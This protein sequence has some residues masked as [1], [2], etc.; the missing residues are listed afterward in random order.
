MTFKPLRLTVCS[1]PV[2]GLNFFPPECKTNPKKLASRENSGKKSLHHIEFIELNACSKRFS[3]F[4]HILYL[5]LRVMTCMF[6][7]NFHA[8]NLKRGSVSIIT[9]SYG[10]TAK[11]VLQL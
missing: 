2:L 5:L 1:Q 6:Q 4:F 10:I 8:A 7:K 9:Q 11:V 3:L